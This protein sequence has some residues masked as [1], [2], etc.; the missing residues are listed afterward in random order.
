M[1][2]RID[3]QPTLNGLQNSIIRFSPEFN[4][5]HNKNAALLVNEYRR[6]ADQTRLV[7]DI[8]VARENQPLNSPKLMDQLESMLKRQVY[9]YPLQVV[10]LLKEIATDEH[11]PLMARNHT[12]R[13]IKA[14]EE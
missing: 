9:S 12:T 10:P 8:A 13:L 5:T 11:L 4:W 6:I 7:F 2:V 3:V 14:I 1:R